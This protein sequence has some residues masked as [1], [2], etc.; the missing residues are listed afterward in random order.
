MST[1]HTGKTLLLNLHP[2]FS[3]VPI[4]L[5]R[6]ELGFVL[7]LSILMHSRTPKI[8]S[9]TPKPTH[10]STIVKILGYP[11]QRRRFSDHIVVFFVVGTV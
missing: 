6:Q 8:I 1:F 5:T 10:R 4:E 9:G 3:T 11:V 7:K 2:V